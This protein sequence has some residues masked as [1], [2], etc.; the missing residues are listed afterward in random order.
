[1]LKIVQRS[2][3]LYEQ[4]SVAV[5]PAHAVE[6]EQRMQT[7]PLRVGAGVPGLRNKRVLMAAGGYSYSMLCTEDGELW[8]FGYNDQGQL[9]LGHRVHN[10]PEPARSASLEGVVVRHVACGQQHT[11]AVGA[12]G[13]SAAPTRPST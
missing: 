13:T 9:G 10:Q 11:L 5:E 8:G 1:M 3:V 4:G 2:E 7:L 6:V 12:D